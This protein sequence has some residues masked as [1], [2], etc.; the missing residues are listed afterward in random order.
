MNATDLTRRVSVPVHKGI[1][2]KPGTLRSIL[3]GAGL[4]PDELKALL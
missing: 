3:K 2:L 4:S 1:D